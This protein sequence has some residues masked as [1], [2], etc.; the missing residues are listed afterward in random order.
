MLIVDDTIAN[1]KAF[2]SVLESENYDLFVAASGQEALKQVLRRDFA[3][4]LMDVRMPDMDGI[5]TATVLRRG[6]GRL[7]PVI[8]VSAHAN[9]PELIDQVYLAGGLDYLPAPVDA[10]V[11]RRKVRA[12]VD[13]HQRAIEYAMKSDELVQTVKILQKRVDELE[14]ALTE[15]RKHA[16]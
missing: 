13:F 10:D 1:Q 12:M 14:E 2:V 11:L 4:I 9:S 3:A 8:F 6:R 15:R 16:D 5:E 7:T